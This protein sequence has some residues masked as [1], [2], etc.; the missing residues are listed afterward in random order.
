MKK[1]FACVGSAPLLW[2]GMFFLIPLLA[3]VLLVLGF[4]MAM[5]IY[6]NKKKHR[7][8]FDTTVKIYTLWFLVVL[9]SLMTY[10]VVGLDFN[11]YLLVL[12]VITLLMLGA[13]YVGERL[14]LFR[15]HHS[16]WIA[17][18]ILALIFATFF[19]ICFVRTI[20]ESSSSADGRQTS[21]VNRL[22]F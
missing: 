13:F 16:R 17:L 6:L 15:V 19:V 4:H 1:N 21:C 2:K 18:T 22:V 8:I 11:F 3:V 10:G 20:L 5:R 7:R 9:L 14:S 12:F